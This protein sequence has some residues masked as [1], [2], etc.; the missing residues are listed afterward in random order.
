MSYKEALYET[1]KNSS[2]LP[3]EVKISKVYE[4]QSCNEQ[5]DKIVLDYTPFSLKLL[6]SKLLTYT[7]MSMKIKAVV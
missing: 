2:K 3:K 4:Y 5:T 7:Y 6:L 1:E